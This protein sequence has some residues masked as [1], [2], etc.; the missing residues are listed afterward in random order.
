[1][2]PAMSAN[3]PGAEY[4]R[5]SHTFAFEEPSVTLYSSAS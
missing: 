4:V 3:S 2:E 1:L 5:L